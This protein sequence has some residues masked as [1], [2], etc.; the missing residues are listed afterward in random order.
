MHPELRCLKVLRRGHAVWGTFKIMS[1]LNEHVITSGLQPCF[2]SIKKQAPKASVTK[3]KLSKRSCFLQRGLSELSVHCSCFLLVYMLMQLR[4][5]EEMRWM[6]PRL[7]RRNCT[8]QFTEQLF[9]RSWTL[10]ADD[11][12]ENQSLCY[13]SS[14]K[15]WNHKQRPNVRQRRERNHGSIRHL[16]TWKKKTTEYF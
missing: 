12:D 13:D 8:S 10:M 11:T 6:Q 3:V 1:G 4:W 9:L 5:N 2:L 14:G 7:S 16:S 15:D